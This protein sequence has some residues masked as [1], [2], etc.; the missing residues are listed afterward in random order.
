MDFLSITHERHKNQNGPHSYIMVQIQESKNYSRKPISPQSLSPIVWGWYNRPVVA[1]VPKVPLHKLKKK[2]K[3]NLRI[4]FKTTNI[5]LNNL[6][7]REEKIDT[8]NNCGV[9]QLK[10]NECPLKYSG[11][12]G[13]TFKVRYKEHI[14]AI[15]TNET[16]NTLNIH[17][18]QDTPWHNQPNIRNTTH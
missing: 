7:P 3:A 4:A 14:Q 16:Q 15:K 18:T 9:C 6:K 8:Y 5:I 13:H 12:T 1:A 17:L 2:V 11:Q 10:C